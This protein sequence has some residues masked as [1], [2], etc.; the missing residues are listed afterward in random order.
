MIFNDVIWF[1]TTEHSSVEQKDGL[2]RFRFTSIASKLMVRGDSVE[3]H[4]VDLVKGLFEP[5]D[6]FLIQHYGC[7]IKQILSYIEEIRNQVQ[8]NLLAH[9]DS[10]VKIDEL[11]RE[12]YDYVDEQGKIQ[13]PIKAIFED[14]LSIDGN[15]NNRD[16]FGSKQSC[17]QKNVWEISP[18][19]RFL[20][21][22][23]NHSLQNL[24][25]TLNSL[26][27]VPM[28]D[29]LSETQLYTIVQ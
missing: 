25:I 22:L 21:I 8:N 26:K 10:L 20:M 11:H 12:F 18:N 29:G 7:D 16:E 2:D 13:K 27:A 4:H 24:E 5:H 28:L 14:F 23:S 6:E 15:R 3:P 19:E 1:F 9:L 17:L